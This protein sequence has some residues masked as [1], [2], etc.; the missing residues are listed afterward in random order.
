M[1]KGALSTS[2]GR[3]WLI[4]VRMS[5]PRQRPPLPGYGTP[6]RARGVR[7]PIISGE[8]GHAPLLQGLKRRDT[9]WRPGV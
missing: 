5:Y 6:P 9:V 7:A 2:L 8:R 4:N 3:P 1:T